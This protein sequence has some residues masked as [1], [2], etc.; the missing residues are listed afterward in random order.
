M[1]IAF[2]VG[3]FPVLSE[4]FILNQIAGLL[5]RGHQVDIYALEGYSGETKVHPIITKYNLLERSDYV[6]AIADKFIKRCWKAVQLLLTHGAK[7]PLAVLRSLNV[8]QYGK[9]AASL[10]LL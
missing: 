1:K 7:N 9:Q 10:R 2:V 6:P 4:A 8:F 5:D 3:R